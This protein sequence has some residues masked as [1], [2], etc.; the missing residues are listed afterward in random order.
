MADWW[1]AQRDISKPF[2]PGQLSE[3][4]YTAFNGGFKGL[5]VQ[6]N[7]VWLNFD[8]AYTDQSIDAVIA[9]HVPIPVSPTPTMEQRMST[10]EAKTAQQD[11][12]ISNLQA[13]LQANIT[14]TNS[15]KVAANAHL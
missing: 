14:L 1:V 10:L 2:D 6:G 4:F 8:K 9:A 11:Q 15:L 3:E 5:G 13:Q 12:T 7:H